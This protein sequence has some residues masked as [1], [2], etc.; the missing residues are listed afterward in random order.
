MSTQCPRC[1]E[2]IIID[3]NNVECAIDNAGAIFCDFCSY[4]I[5]IVNIEENIEK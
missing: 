2:K 4:I 1:G 3:L 5:D